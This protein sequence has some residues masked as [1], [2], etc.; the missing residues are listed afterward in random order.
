MEMLIARH[1]RL[2]QIR[3]RNLAFLLLSKSVFRR[4]IAIE[5]ARVKN[6]EDDV[7]EDQDS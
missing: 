7:E 5:D 2:L 6:L 3:L 4:D 1:D